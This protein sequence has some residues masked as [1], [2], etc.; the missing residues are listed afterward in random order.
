[1]AKLKIARLFKP[2]DRKVVMGLRQTTE[3]ATAIED[4]LAMRPEPTGLESTTGWFFSLLLD[5]FV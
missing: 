4:E 1:M 2:L 5:L 3:G